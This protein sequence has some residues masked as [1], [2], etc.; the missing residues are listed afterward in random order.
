MC[1]GSIS[2]TLPD[3]FGDK[4]HGKITTAVYFGPASAHIIALGCLI[5]A[6]PASL[7][8][9]ADY[10]ALSCA[11]LVIPIYILYLINPSV[12]NMELAYKMGGTVTMIAA[13]L[14]VPLLLPA[15]ILVFF[16]TR[17]YFRKRYG[18]AYPAVE[19]S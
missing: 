19:Q 9:S 7:L 17:L 13:T 8:I 18:I 6:V 10:L 1:A 3:I 12:K 15:G 2:S 11:V 16:A 14:A 4:A 5:A